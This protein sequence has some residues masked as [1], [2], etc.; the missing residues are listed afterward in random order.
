VE[1]VNAFRDKPI[2]TLR[3]AIERSAAQILTA[4]ESAPLIRSFLD[5][6]PGVRVEIS[7]DDAHGDIIS[8]RFDAGIRLGQ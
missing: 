3:L 8:G 7:I 4:R 2:G 5:E 6:Y 1:S